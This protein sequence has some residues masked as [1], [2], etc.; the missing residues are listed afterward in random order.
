MLGKGQVCSIPTD[1]II[2]L[3]LNLLFS[4]STVHI[5]VRLCQI[6]EFIFQRGPVDFRSVVN[7]RHL[8]MEAGG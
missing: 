7:L 3:P 1:P 5:I 6:L 2:F 8:G 4:S